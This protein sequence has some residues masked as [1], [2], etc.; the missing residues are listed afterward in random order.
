MELKR[1]LQQFKKYYK[2]KNRNSTQPGI[3]FIDCIEIQVKHLHL[4]LHCLN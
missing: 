1:N 2:L 4:I 3:S